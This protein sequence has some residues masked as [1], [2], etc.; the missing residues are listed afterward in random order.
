MS[1]RFSLL[2]RSSCQIAKDTTSRPICHPASS[3]AASSTITTDHSDA[4][5]I[6]SDLDLAVRIIVIVFLCAE[7]VYLSSFTAFLTRFRVPLAYLPTLTYG[8]YLPPYLPTYCA[9]GKSLRVSH[10]VYSPE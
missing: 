9:L 2:R 4:V 1:A 8:T 10:D 5:D 6:P 7:V 3:D